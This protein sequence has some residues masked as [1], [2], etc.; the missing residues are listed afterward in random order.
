MKALVAGWCPK[1]D[2]VY[3][4]ADRC[5]DCG[6]A[7]VPLET[8][9]EPPR[10]DEH[11]SVV[12][13]DADEP[14]APVPARNPWLTRLLLATAL[15]A[16]FLLGLILPRG[17]PE[18]LPS[19]PGSRAA[20][21]T[22]TPVE[23]QAGGIDGEIRMLSLTQNGER[24]T[25]DFRTVLGFD[26]PR[27]IE[28]AAVEVTTVSEAAGE[29]TFS[30]SAVNLVSDS[31][32]FTIAGRLDAPGIVLSLRITSIQVRAEHTPE[33]RVNL[34]SALPVRGP[35]PSLVRVT[36]PAQEVAGGSVRLTTILGWQDRVE[37]VFELKGSDGA[38]GVRSEIVGFDMLVTPAGS[39]GND[40][41]G[42]SITA[43]QIDQVS[44]AQIMARFES[45]PD[46]A[47]TVTIRA[48]RVLNFLQG[49]WNWRLG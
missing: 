49:P 34:S 40:V 3:A 5:P 21:R 23:P 38:P 36:Q 32:G 20:A 33:W 17:E 22:F 25:A 45:V 18:T 12:D 14:A 6:T 28:G 47:G 39:T 16:A 13:A 44:A 15:V 8:E 35:P 29:S 19:A 43:S 27:R 11:R 46:N 37:A 2:R 9:K 7:L 48:S 42:R 24:V 30:L 31:R 26:D 4:K 10:R 1:H 41:Q